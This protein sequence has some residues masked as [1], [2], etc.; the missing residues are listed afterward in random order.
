MGLT[1]KRPCTVVRF[2]PTSGMNIPALVDVAVPSRTQHLLK[3]VSC[4]PHANGPQKL[5]ILGAC[6]VL[7]RLS[8][9]EQVL[10]AL[11]V[12]FRQLFGGF[13]VSLG[14]FVVKIYTLCNPEVGMRGCLN[15]CSCK[16]HTLGFGKVNRFL[17][18]ITISFDLD[19]AKQRCT[20]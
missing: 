2:V 16:Q 9:G 18:F 12:S 6:S 7:T 20:H 15:E 10:C 4:P 11:Y 19:M 1:P 17:G 14:S 13:G 5:D 8:S 3:L